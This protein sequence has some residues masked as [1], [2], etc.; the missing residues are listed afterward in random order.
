MASASE[1][2]AELRLS[3]TV[4]DIQLGH[5]SHIVYTQ[6]GQ[7]QQ[8]LATMVVNAAGPWVNKVL[9]HTQPT[10]RR[11]EIEWV[12]GTHI[13]LPGQLQQGFYYLES[14][15]D[16]RA[17]FVMP[18]QGHIMVGTTETP[19]RGDPAQVHPLDEEQ[20]YLLQTLS[21]YFPTYRHFTRGDISHAFAGL[22]VLPTGSGSAF[23]RP[24]ETTLLFDQPSPRLVS[25]YGGKLTAY[26]AT[27]ELLMHKLTPYL[28]SRKKIADT[29]YLPLPIPAP[30]R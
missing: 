3:A 15:Q 26:R 25:I 24:R 18:W 13:E 22:R 16:Q 11:Q 14:P 28:P 20:D 5:P 10:P 17:V 29:R 23:Q 12:Q 7:E 6:Q 9:D 8:C 30:R 4:Q 19:Y 1:L 27:A 21:H 2:G